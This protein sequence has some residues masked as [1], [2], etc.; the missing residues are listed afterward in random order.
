MKPVIAALLGSPLQD[1]NTA[2]VLHH[3][4]AGATES[5]C[6]VRRIDIFSLEIIPCR[7]FNLCR[8]HPACMIEDDVSALY[9]FFQEIDGLIMATPVMTM[10]VPGAFK[11]FMDRFQVFY[12]AKYER[13]E[14]MVSKEKRMHRRTLLISL[15]GMN[16]PDNF[17]GLRQTADAF[18]D[19]IDAPITGE[20]YIQDMDSKRAISRFPDI[21]EEARRKGRELGE[22]ILT[23]I[24]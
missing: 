18:C 21:L 15:S 9:P 6:E 10:G 7:E 17:I 8:N 4:I 20:L 24:S 23:R 5:G 19:I 1:G 14:R 2:Q 3:A 11:S 13:K 22:E 16:L 12:C